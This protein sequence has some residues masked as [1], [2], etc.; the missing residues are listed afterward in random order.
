MESPGSSAVHSCLDDDSLLALTEGRL[1]ARERA[2]A[3]QHVDRCG[4]CRQVLAALIR[5]LESQAEHEIPNA[6][7][8][9]LAERYALI[10]EL[11]RG[12]HGTVYAARE[13][14]RAELVRLKWID[15]ALAQRDGVAAR[16][17]EACRSLEP[18]A[19]PNLAPVWGCHL[20]G[21]TLV[22]VG[23]LAEGD[24][25]PTLLA[26]RTLS[27]DL[28]REL[29]TQVT[30]ALAEA[31]RLGIVHG[32][33]EPNNVIVDLT[34]QARLTDFALKTAISG[35]QPADASRA[36]A[37]AA[38]RIALTLLDQAGIAQG[39]LRSIFEHCLADQSAFPSACELAE[40]LSTAT[41]GG[42]SGEEPWIPAPGELIGEKYRVV[43]LLGVG[44]MGAVVTATQLDLGRRV[45]IKLMPPRAARRPAAVERFLREA[46]AASAIEND[47][48]VRV[49][50]VGKS[51]TGTPFMV[52]EHLDGV[53]LGTLVARRGPLPVA[54][55]IDIVL[56][57][58]IA[59]AECHAR[60]IVHRDLKPDNV[61]VLE[62]PGQRGFVKVLDFGVSK[63]DWLEA[64]AELGRLTHTMEMLGTPTYM[65]P[66]QVRSSKSVDPRTD[67]WAIGVL[68]YELLSGRPPFSAGSVPALSA[69]I[70]SDDP[71]PLVA[72]RSD[73]SLELERVIR[74]C[75]EKLPGRRPASVAE[76]TE[77]L[78]PFA[79]S[80]SLGWVERIRG[81][82][83]ADLPR[84]SSLPPPPAPSPSAPEP[85]RAPV[86]LDTTGT[87]GATPLRRFTPR[88]IKAAIVAAVAVLTGGALAWSALSHGGASGGAGPPVQPAVAQPGPRIDP[89]PNHS[90]PAGEIIPAMRAG[91]ADGGVPKRRRSGPAPRRGPLDERF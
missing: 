1:D 60:G 27:R 79:S 69:M 39:S 41:A 49:F 14:G 50:D 3:E 61:M 35:E 66:E 17:R 87:W 8:G 2:L 84:I 33:L 26:S 55:A 38:S 31:H 81:I 30:L 62:R 68:L 73:V 86:R 15:Q 37:L 75:L 90:I 20:H 9:A 24:D 25:L 47:H 10:R 23:A 91:A 4:D 7:P 22:I 65:S 11:G 5:G 16:L 40:A 70:V 78:L 28:A 67:I 32:R 83:G 19:H 45:A 63:A 53:T 34:G 44:G 12:P 74:R 59:V 54:E 80:A 6:L 88:A 82:A 58:S 76:L 13:R 77:L 64:D 29:V 48:V 89:E 72:Q 21:H 18:L 57:T 85:A 71:A 56:Q 46:R 43:G 36:D 42:R 52:M 51:A